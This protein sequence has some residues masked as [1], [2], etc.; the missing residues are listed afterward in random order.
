M[1]G[2]THGVA[3]HSPRSRGFKKNRGGTLARG[4]AANDRTSGLL[5]R[6]LYG[7]TTRATA[8]PPSVATTIGST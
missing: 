6:S 4:N 3:S 7:R 2:Q 1:S 8:T 5:E